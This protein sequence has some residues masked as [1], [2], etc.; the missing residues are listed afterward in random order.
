[1]KKLNILVLPEK[2]ML[3]LLIVISIA[4]GALSYAGHVKNANFCKAI[5]DISA[6]AHLQHDLQQSAKP[7]DLH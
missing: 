3:T 2:I 4:C 5:R 7:S 6:Q 1:M